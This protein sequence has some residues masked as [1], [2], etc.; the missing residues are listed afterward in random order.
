MNK[1]TTRTHNTSWSHVEQNNPPHMRLFLFSCT[2]AQAKRHVVNNDRVKKKKTKN[3]AATIT[4]IMVLSRAPSC[5]RPTTSSGVFRQRNWFFF[6]VLFF[7]NVIFSLNLNSRPT[8]VSNAGR[9]KSRHSYNSC[10]CC[11]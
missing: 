5:L 6:P 8:E 7:F 4:F 10:L 9:L 11:V 2:H 3:P 1:N